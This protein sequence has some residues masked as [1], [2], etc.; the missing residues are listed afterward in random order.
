[1]STAPLPRP[2]IQAENLTIQVHNGAVLQPIVEDLDLTVGPGGMTVLFGRSGSGKTT[3]LKALS[4]MIPPS[5]GII[6]WRGDPIN[7]MHPDE[8][9]R[10]RVGF[11]GYADQQSSLIARFTA[12]ENIMLAAVPGRQVAQRTET[13]RELLARVGLTHRVDH[14]VEVLSGG[15]RQRVCLVRALLMDP[16][17]IVADEPTASLDRSTADGII[18]LLAERAADGRTV[19]TA[20]HD[21]HVLQAADQSVDIE[22]SQVTSALR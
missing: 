2:D 21:P 5:S 16:E 11:L 3:V 13:A 20:S 14:R 7:G 15:E 22:H 10:R 9:A 4:G 1:M 8:L 18:S 17:V 19:L 12:L 6:R